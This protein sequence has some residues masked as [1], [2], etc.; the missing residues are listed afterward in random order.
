ML[1][2]GHWRA[3]RGSAERLIA[4]A[5]KVILTGGR[6]DK[7]WN[8]SSQ[9]ECNLRVRTGAGWHKNRPHPD[10]GSSSFIEGVFFYPKM[11]HIHMKCDLG[12]LW[13]YLAFCGLPVTLLELWGSHWL[14][15]VQ[16]ALACCPA[17]SSQCCRQTTWWES[18]SG[19]ANAIGQQNRE[20]IFELFPGGGA[21]APEMPREKDKGITRN[22]HLL[23]THRLHCWLF[24]NVY[25]RMLTLYMIPTWCWCF[26][27]SSPL[28]AS[29]LLTEM[30]SVKCYR[31]QRPTWCNDKV[32]SCLFLWLEKKTLTPVGSPP[33][34]W[35]RHVMSV[36]SSSSSGWKVRYLYFNSSFIRRNSFFL[37]VEVL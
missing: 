6:G 16:W 12:L 37:I 22:P 31:W 7:W 11:G 28:P 3:R 9:E 21:V 33:S 10:R 1:E 14:M 19:E 25:I 23:S 2:W 18:S 8:F 15:L 5:V 20:V 26:Y 30:M 17:K 34:T 27:C 13:L 4:K 24:I 29:S 32:T 36:S 35:V